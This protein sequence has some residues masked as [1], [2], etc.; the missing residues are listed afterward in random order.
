MK[1][2]P[3]ALVLGAACVA[4]TRDK[5]AERTMLALENIVSDEEFMFFQ[6][7]V[8]IAKR[9]HWVRSSDRVPTSSVK[10]GLPTAMVWSGGTP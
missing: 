10:R 6:R 2:G 5:I 3:G 7:R 8:L 1:A 4:T 9:Q